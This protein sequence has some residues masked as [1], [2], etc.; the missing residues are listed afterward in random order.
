MKL[1]T[2]K[3]I[4]NGVITI[5]ILLT[6]TIITFSL[7]ENP[8][9]ELE[10]YKE[11]VKKLNTK[12]SDKATEINNLNNK[13]TTYEDKIKELES[14]VCKG[15]SALNEKSCEYIDTYEFKDYVDYTSGFIKGQFFI[16]LDKEM[17]KEPPVLLMLDE[18][19]YKKDFIKNQ[20]YEITFKKTIYYNESNQ[21]LNE[22]IDVIKIEPTDLKGLE[23]NGT[24]CILR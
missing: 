9:F 2:K 1:L 10:N 3:N 19:K 17:T 14:E 7:K 18:N 13:I 15:T 5:L 21:V 6:I 20:S 12:L 22:K 24:N 23:Q 8:N 4:I 16:L 11:E